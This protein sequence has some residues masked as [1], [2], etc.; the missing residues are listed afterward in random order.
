MGKLTT[1]KGS[2]PNAVEKRQRY[3][4]IIVVGGGEGGGPGFVMA[5]YAALGVVKAGVGC[6]RGT[7]VRI[8]FVKMGVLEGEVSI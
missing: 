7:G 2:Y 8:N 3:G 1:K 6:L 4:S 5:E